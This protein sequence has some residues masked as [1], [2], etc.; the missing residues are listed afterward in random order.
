M[1]TNKMLL[2]SFLTALSFAG[3][4]EDDNIEYVN[5]GS[6]LKTDVVI[7]D[8][9]NL[10]DDYTNIADWSNRFK[11]N[12][13]NVHDPSVV[14]ADDGYYYMYQTD[15]SYGN[16]HVGE[17]QARG[18]F[19]CRRSKD[20]V[21]WE[22]MG[23]TMHGVPTWMKAKLN[24]I[25]KA[26]G[27]GTSTTDFRNQ[28]QFGYWAPCVRRISK[29][30]YRMYYVVTLPGT[31]NGA[32]TWSERCFIGLMETKN[33][34]DIDSWVDKGYVVTNYSDLELNYKVS[35]TDYAHC[36]FKYNAIDPSLIIN[37]K[38]EHWLIYGSWHSGFA[39]MQLDPSTGKPLHALGNPWG[40]ENEASY[41][42]FIYT[43]QL[44]NRWQASEAPEVVYHDGYYYLFIAYD[45]LSV[46][47]NTRV[48]RS[49]NI[50]GPYYD[51]T[52]KDVTNH[53]G[54]A[55]PI[56]THPYKFGNH[57]GWV[58]ISHCAVFNDGKGNWYY[59]SQ[60]RFPENYKGNANSNALMLGGVRSI[61][62]TSDGWP[63]VLPERYAGITQKAITETELLGDWQ[64]INLAY[65]YKKQ[66]ASVAMTLGN[67][68]KVKS[69]W[70][71]GKAWTF[72][73]SK[74]VLTI[75]N[76][77]FYLRRELDWEANPRKETIVYVGLSKD[78]KT[79]YWGKKV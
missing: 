35:A 53:G 30:L 78:G 7:T 66:D 75:D 5:P 36:Y 57:H 55:Y 74:N 17:G 49:K 79:T 20:L 51:I 27:L 14:L 3:C 77:R 38:G 39:A 6:K 60:Q 54:D 1:K 64:H 33:P 31:I 13:A 9:Q 11:W 45:E 56:L 21:N 58:G 10:N 70:K 73:A 41:G 59:A 37:E 47:Y 12:L 71:A 69:G 22:F 63:L 61:I 23:P 26:M 68:H 42:K 2:I 25:R 24:E 28:N 43:R 19:Y 44:G 76:E 62:W 46:A 15:A 40:K 18:H 4:S 65:H 29:D 32:G 16:A 52:G 8:G 50:D 67:D 48:V 72:D 34:A